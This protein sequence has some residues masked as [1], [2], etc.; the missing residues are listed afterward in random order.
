MTRALDIYGG[1]SPRDLALYS[2]A[3]AAR[4]V[5]VNAATLRTWALGRNYP[6]REGDRRW[7]PLIRAADPKHKRLS[8]TNLVELHVLSALRGKSVRVDRIRKATRFLRDSLGTDHP[9]ADTDTHTDCVDVYVEYLGQLVNASSAQATLRPIVERYL[10][11][12]D[13]D[14]RGLARR[15]FPATR[16]TEDLGPKLVVIDPARRF[17]R[18]VVSGSGIETAIIAERFHAGE[19]ARDLAIDFE[20]AEDA[21]EEAVRFETAL[22]RAA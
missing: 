4:I 22:R 14:E 11:R 6:T 19:S 9:L 13:R 8:F 1:K 12:I 10:T 16:D 17:G 5:R 15:L 18:P 3:D 2:V 20:I 21:I 7:E